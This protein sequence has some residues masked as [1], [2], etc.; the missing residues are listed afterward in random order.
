MPNLYSWV[1][2]VERNGTVETSASEVK[3]DNTRK[4]SERIPYFL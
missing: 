1:K 4:K 2:T 3:E